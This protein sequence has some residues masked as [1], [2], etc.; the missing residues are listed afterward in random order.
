[1]G[2]VKQRKQK[3]EVVIQPVILS[4]G[5]GSRLW[6]LSLEAYPKQLIPLFD[7]TSL[8]Q[9][10]VLRLSGLAV[11]AP[12]VVCAESQRFLVASQLQEIGCIP[13]ATLLEPFGRNTA[14]ALALAAIQALSS[15]EDCVLLVL[16]ADHLIQEPEKFHQAVHEAIPYANQGNFVT[17]GVIPSSPHTGYG[18]IQKGEALG[19]Y[20][21]QVKQFVE[22]PD[23]KTAEAYVSSKEFYWN[24][25]MFLFRAST[26][27]SALKT[28][29]P[30]VLLASQQAMNKQ[31]T[32]LDF[33]RIDAEAFARAPDISIDYAVMEKVSNRVVIPFD[34]GWSDVGSWENLCEVSPK[35]AEGN[36]VHGDVI[37]S[38]V[39]NSYIRSEGRLVV[40]LGL[41]NLIVVETADAVLVA[42]KSC[43]QLVRGIVSHLKHHQREE[44][45]YHREQ[46]FPWGSIELLGEG[47]CTEVRHFKVRAHRRTDALEAM[48]LMHYWIIVRGNAEIE[49]ESGV[50]RLREKSFFN[51][52][53]KE[54]YMIRN[55]GSEMLEFVEVRVGIFN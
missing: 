39:T 10:T 34:A 54:G 5:S 18:Y 48:S 33:S 26:Y 24:S 51:P 21:Y 38:Q 4:G 8:L 40:A 14:P 1:M 43:G 36:S 17:F 53:E 41:K 28:Y 6:P 50:F 27:L 35:D 42:D 15:G 25:G 23:A 19:K 55:T 2:D 44:H 13:K 31:Q 45:L 16:S 12:I 52:K 29:A 9:K 32:D 3:T 46:H 22:K 7:Q 37:T 47:P 11:E 49:G 20:G 30:E